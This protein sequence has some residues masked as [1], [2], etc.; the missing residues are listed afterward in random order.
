[1]CGKF[2]RRGVRLGFA[3]SQIL[4][5]GDVGHGG[6]AQLSEIAVCLDYGPQYKKA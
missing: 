3:P 5:R 4:E 1:M 6:V 2:S